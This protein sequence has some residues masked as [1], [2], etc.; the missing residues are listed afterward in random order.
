VR[1]P[2]RAIVFP[3]LPVAVLAIAPSVGAAPVRFSESPMLAQEV[4]QGRL[5][6]VQERLPFSPRVLN[7]AEPGQ[8]GGTLRMLMAK[9]KDVRMLVVYGYARLV[10]YDQKF[11]LMPDI[12]ASVDVKNDRIFTLHLR[13]GQKWSD[14]VPFTSD[15][16]RYWWEDVANNHDLSPF[17]IPDQMMVN[18]KPPKFEIIDATTVRYSWSAPNPYFLPGGGGAVYLLTGTLPEAVSRALCGFEETGGDGQE[19]GCARLV[20]VARAQ[21]LA[22]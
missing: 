2:L 3:L 12:L 11:A 14:G 6:P 1:R 9:E 22:L 21:G 16:F 7:V 10:G 17:G 8:Y 20:G 13:K 15:D 5:P 18:N 4:A 19:G